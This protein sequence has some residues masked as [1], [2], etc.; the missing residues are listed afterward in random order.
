MTIVALNLEVERSLTPL[1]LQSLRTHAESAAGSASAAIRE[2]EF[3]AA[4][5]GA[6]NI[7][8]QSLRSRRILPTTRTGAALAQLLSDEM[9]QRTMVERIAFLR[10]SHGGIVGLIAR[11]SD[12]V[13]RVTPYQSAVEDL[14]LDWKSAGYVLLTANRGVKLRIVAPLAM[15]SKGAVIYDI[16]LAAIL[17]ELKPLFEGGSILLADHQARLVVGDPQAW[18]QLSAASRRTIGEGGQFAVLS[19]AQASAS[20]PLQLGAGFKGA[21]VEV[22]PRRAFLAG[23]GQVLAETTLAAVLITLVLAGLLV[24][25]IVGRNRAEERFE[26]AI[27]AAP[28]GMLLVERDGAISF[29]N[30]E[31]ERMFGYGAGALA[32]VKIEELVPAQF[33]GQHAQFRATFAQSPSRRAMGAGRD[34]LA[35]RADGSEFPAEIALMPIQMWRRIATLVVVVDITERKRVE[36][37]LRRSNE[38]LEQ[39]AYLASHD[40][41]E[42]LRMVAGFTQL[43]ADKYSGKLDARA[44]NYIRHASEG[45]RRLQALVRDML[46]YSRLSSTK[47]IASPVDVAALVA[48]TE[49]FLA[50]PMA[51]AMAQ[52]SVVDVLPNAMADKTQ[53]R[54]VLQN[55]IGNALKFR[56]DGPV[57]ILIRGVRA[58]SMAIY[59]VEDNGIGIEEKNFERVF[60]MFQRLHDRGRYE[61][62]GIGLAAVK[63]IVESLGGRVWIES[64]IGRGTKISF[65]LPIAGG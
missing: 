44:D 60:Q 6:S 63:K 32:K 16:D 17:G 41:Q 52:I 10:L 53:L 13:V 19:E 49:T 36:D 15:P 31:S 47:M 43:L 54:R 8:R 55:L 40:I 39:F 35:R 9:R 5:I 30:S 57:R 46:D 28:N 26:T 3:A 11:R 59:S 33:R 4:T 18:P 64:A 62:S 37:A 23:V 25:G 42:P 27:E 34:L 20:A 51:A 58:G 29:A 2:I 7:A 14:P 65:S 22:A 48:E 50:V 56:S 45:A 21:L 38:E 1:R 24:R 61:G 12:G